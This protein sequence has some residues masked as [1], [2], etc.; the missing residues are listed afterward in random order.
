[1]LPSDLSS[2]LQSALDDS[3][4]CARL[5]PDID[6]RLRSALFCSRVGEKLQAKLESSL[7]GCTLHHIRVA[8]ETGKRQK[9]EWLLDMVIADGDLTHTPITQVHVAMECE[10]Q[11]STAALHAD[12]GKLLVIRAATKL[13]LH[14]LNQ[15]TV[16]GADDLIEERIKLAAGW[17]QAHDDPATQWYLGFWP[18]PEKTAHAASIWDELEP[19]QAFAHLRQIRLFEFSGTAGEFRRV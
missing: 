12:F 15:Q 6:N 4:C 16:D 3:L 1:M 18:S 14:G 5:I 2:L 17:I 9:G 13:Y 10:S 8:P 19:G 11:T 7:P